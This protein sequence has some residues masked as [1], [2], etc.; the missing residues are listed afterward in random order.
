MARGDDE[1]ANDDWHLE[2]L[3]AGQAFAGAL[4]VTATEQHYF[5]W[6]L[7]GR[8][9]GRR[10]GDGH[11]ASDQINN[12]CSSPHFP[13]GKRVAYL[14]AKRRVTKPIEQNPKSQPR[15][16]KTRLESKIHT[17]SKKF[18]TLVRESHGDASYESIGNGISTFN[19]VIM[20]PRSTQ[21]PVEEIY[22]MPRRQAEKSL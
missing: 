16:T 4:E 14:D 1:T 2:L 18:N 7:W 15:K 21:L 17:Q 8:L 22:A 20:K 19:Y 11:H 3:R 9:S 10:D 6:R 5:A 12:H 13:L